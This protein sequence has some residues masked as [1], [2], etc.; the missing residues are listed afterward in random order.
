MQGALRWKRLSAP[1]PQSDF[2]YTLLHEVETFGVN[3][4]SFCLKYSHHT[5]LLP[6][7]TSVCLHAKQD[8]YRVAA[9]RGFLKQILPSKKKIWLYA[10][11]PQT[12]IIVTA[13]FSLILTVMKCSNVHSVFFNLG[14]FGPYW[15]SYSH[16]GLH[17]CRGCEY[18]FVLHDWEL[19]MVFGHFTFTECI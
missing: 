13:Y 18:S 3:K 5:I 7:G 9:L 2:N 4:P 12:S 19:C 15:I 16:S 6:A 1:L 8:Y 10:G 11:D 14:L 17:T